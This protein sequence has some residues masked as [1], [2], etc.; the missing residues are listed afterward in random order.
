MI[1]RSRFMLVTLLLVMTW[2]YL[3]FH[4]RQAI[5]V[6]RPLAEFPA[7]YQGWNMISQEQFGD[8]LLKVLK[9]SDYLARQYE[10][11]NGRQ[12]GLYIGYHNGSRESGEIHSPK[13]CLPGS[14]WQQ[15]TTTQTVLAGLP[16]TIHLTRA[17]YQKGDNKELFLYWFQVRDKSI[18]D[19]YALKLSGIASAILYG[20]KDASFIRI[21]VP[22]VV[23]E[24][25][26]AAIGTS[27][28]R[29]TYPM[30]RAFLPS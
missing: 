23:N 25:E 17:V 1:A 16:D 24:H 14:G 8:D 3:F 20:R 26:A 27:F 7:S 4:T 6:A 29:D 18:S 11:V 13:N 22:F 10:A 12:V 19:E 15:V 5:P 21:S 28:I 9:P 30:I 2:L